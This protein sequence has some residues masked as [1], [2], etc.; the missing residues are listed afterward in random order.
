MHKISAFGQRNVKEILRDPLSY[1]FCVGFPLVMLVIMTLVDRSIPREAGM[2][3]FRI[4]NLAGAIAACGFIDL[5]KVADRTDYLAA[6]ETLLDGMIDHC[7]DFE[8][9]ICGILTHCTAS[10]HDDGAGR[11]TNIIYGDYFLMEALNKLTG[12]DPMLWI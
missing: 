11:H 9:T 5:S 6:A 7:A 12:N 1:I 10:Y 8:D 3:I 4:D 2:T